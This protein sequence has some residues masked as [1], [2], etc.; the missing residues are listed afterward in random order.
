MS[1]L[2]VSWQNDEEHNEE[3]E[4]EVDYLLEFVSNNTALYASLTKRLCEEAER[5]V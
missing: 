4:A 5:E 2:L 3:E 1:I